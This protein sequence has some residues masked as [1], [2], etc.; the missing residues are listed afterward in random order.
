LDCD[1]SDSGCNGGWPYNAYQYIINAG[2][3]ETES[4][5][6]YTAQDG[7]CAF[8]PSSIECKVQSWKYVI[9]N[10]D[11]N[12]MQNFVFTNS[13]VSVCV[14][15]SSW[16]FYT[17]GVI[18]QSSGCGNSIDHCV[19]VT[20][21]SVQQGINAWNVRNSW[22]TS[23]G[24]NGYLYVQIGYDVCSIAEVVTVPCVQSQS[25]GNTVC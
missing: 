24:V 3:I 9:Q 11:E 18:T 7:N 4:A 19:Q 10:K 1:Q 8:N 12:A 5:Y 2:G 20:G 14:D 16:Q 6:P 23:W 13:P 21:W 15:A 17:G 22:G 25:G